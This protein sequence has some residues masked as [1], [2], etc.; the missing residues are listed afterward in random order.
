MVPT[1]ASSSIYSWYVVTHT[2][3]WRVRVRGSTSKQMM[4]AGVE[5]TRDFTTTIAASPRRC[6]T[7]RR[8][9]ST[10]CE[11][12]HHHP[13][14]RRWT[15]SSG[16]HERRCYG[17]SNFNISIQT[18]ESGELYYFTHGFADARKR[19]PSN[20]VKLLSR[21]L[22]T[23]VGVLP[24]TVHISTLPTP[25]SHASMKACVRVVVRGMPST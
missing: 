8:R 12:C 22:R 25:T 15:P 14:Q 24:R 18:C 5:G 10:T 3:L 17:S 11:V 1:R 4:G 7:R 6:T 16:T 21:L 2:R 9:I 13:L 19:A 20:N 23:L